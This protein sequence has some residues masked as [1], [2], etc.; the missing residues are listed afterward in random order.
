LAGAAD[1]DAA[2]NLSRSNACVRLTH[3][4]QRV[5]AR[6]DGHSNFASVRSAKRRQWIPS[7]GVNLHVAAARAREAAAEVRL[8]DA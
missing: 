1:D 7:E 8:F 3:R 5:I 4:E 6:V 2:V